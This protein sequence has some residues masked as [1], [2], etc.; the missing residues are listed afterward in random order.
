MR[1]YLACILYSDNYREP[2]FLFFK[3]ISDAHEHIRNM[4]KDCDHE[5]VTMEEVIEAV[6]EMDETEFFEHLCELH[7]IPCSTVEYLYE[8]DY[9]SSERKK[10][11]HYVLHRRN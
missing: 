6:D 4:T 9:G 7:G 8:T 5:F 2:T 3:S 1:A 10:K 11:G